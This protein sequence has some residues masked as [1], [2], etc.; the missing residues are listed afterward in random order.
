MA[1]THA[2]ENEGFFEAHI[3]RLTVRLT[4][5]LNVKGEENTWGAPLEDL[6]NS[7]LFLIPF[8]CT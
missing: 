6:F 3:L 5:E 8:P 7:Q 2:E 1:F 4:V